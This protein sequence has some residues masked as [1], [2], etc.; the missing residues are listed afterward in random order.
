MTVIRERITVDNAG[1]VI[2]QLAEVDRKVRN[3]TVK[4][5]TVAAGKETLARAK[6]V[7]SQA[8]V[9]GFFGRSLKQI[10]KTKA[11]RT[12]AR[13]GQ[14]KQK[15]FKARKSTRVK[16]KNLSQIQRAGKAVPIHWLERGTKPHTITAAG[17]GNTRTYSSGSNVLAFR[18]GRKVIYSRSV[19]NP[20]SGAQ[21]ILERTARGSRRKAA[22]AFAAV[23][24]SDLSTV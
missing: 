7:A 19:R 12:T 18:I 17:R 13:I 14:E 24:K 15:S 4:R 23:V 3:R 16:G 21:R 22:A 8:K 20:G 5:A 10:N 9:T 2:K 1:A 11:G 6:I